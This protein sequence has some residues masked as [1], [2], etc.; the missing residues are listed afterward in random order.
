[1]KKK[2]M[3]CLASLVLIT[4]C[5]NR[6]AEQKGADAAKEKIDFVKG[7]AD[8]VKKQGEDTANTVAEG[9]GN[10]IKGL[11][12]GFDK[13]LVEYDVRI[14]DSVPATLF[15]VTRAQRIEWSADE[16]KHGLSVYVSSQ[17]GFEGT[18]RLI[19][20]SDAGEVGRSKAD[21][22]LGKGDAA[23]FDFVF[24]ARTPLD[25]VKYYSLEK[26]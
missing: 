24:D 20:Y 4:A 13:A 12:K 1:M 3:V 9:A 2:L 23:Y 6:T 5:D 11:D 19:A 17:E 14:P 15:S 7:A 25:V 16:K 26:S 10:I 21:V 18:L 8:L 22:K